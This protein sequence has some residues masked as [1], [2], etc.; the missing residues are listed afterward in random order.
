[1]VR[2][3]TLRLPDGPTGAAELLPSW[4][5]TDLYDGIDSPALA[6]DLAV[7]QEHAS[8]FRVDYA[9]KLAALPARGTGGG[10]GPLRGN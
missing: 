9:D 4:D 8:A 10:P 6:H 5:L 7:A 1:M 3:E 2:V